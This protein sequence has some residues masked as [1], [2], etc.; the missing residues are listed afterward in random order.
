M[1]MKCELFDSVK[2][3]KRVM[4]LV[5]TNLFSGLIQYNTIDMLLLPCEV[6]IYVSG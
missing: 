3:Y 5:K 6:Y 4:I 2:Q 1:I